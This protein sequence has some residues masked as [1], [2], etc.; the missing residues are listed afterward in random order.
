MR[1]SQEDIRALAAAYGLQK[2]EKPQAACLAS[3][4]PYGTPV[5]R[6]LL[7]RIAR[8]EQVLRKMGFSQYRV[9]HHGDVARLELAPHEFALAIDRHTELV[10]AIK[11][12]GYAFVALD[13]AGFRSGSL[14]HAIGEAKRAESAAKESSVVR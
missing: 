11:A 12:C 7:A 2:A 8:A 4:V 5:S 10:K 1:L 6:E 14:N 13:L 9:R 3:R